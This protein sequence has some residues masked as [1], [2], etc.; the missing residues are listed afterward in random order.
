M[1]DRPVSQGTTIPEDANTI[2][3]V[4]VVSFQFA[5]GNGN[6]IGEPS[7]GYAEIVVDDQLGPT[8]NIYTS[9]EQR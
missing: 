4:E 5:D 2:N 1:T 8:L 7:K 6:P 9:R 3:I